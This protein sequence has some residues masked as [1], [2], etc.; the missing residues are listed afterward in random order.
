[1]SIRVMLAGVIAMLL[2]LTSCSI[3]DSSQ[4]LQP[5]IPEGESYIAEDSTF[6]STVDIAERTQSFSDSNGDLWPVAWSDDDH[7][8]TANGD[9]RGFDWG[10][11][12]ADIVVNRVDGQPA[13]DSMSGE[14]LASGVEVGQVWSDPDK[15]NK[16]PTGMISVDG[17][18]YMAVQDLNKEKSAATF[19]DV[20]AATIIKSTDKGLTW[21]WDK[22]KPMFSNYQFTTIMFLDYGK[23]GENNTFDDY[24]Y[25]YGLDYNWR[26][27][28]SD[29]VPDPTK[30]YLARMPKTAL[31]DVT[32]WEYYTGDLYGYARW[33]EPSKIEEKKPVL[34]DDRRVYTDLLQDGL[35]NMSVIS[36]SSIVYNKPLERYIYS[37]WTEFTF[38]FYEAPTP[39]GPWKKFLSKD[40]GVYPWTHEKHGGYATVIPSKFISENGK[41]MW[42]NGNTFVGGIEIYSFSLRK[43]KVTPYEK[44]KAK[45]KKNDGVNLALSKNGKDATTLT[46]SS[47]Y[48]NSHFMNDG[49]KEQSE[50][51]WNGEIKKE[52]YWGYTWSQAYRMNQLVYTTGQMFGTDGG[53]FEDMKVQVRQDFV[54]KDVDDLVISHDYSFDGGAGANTSYTLDF[55]NIWGDGVRLIGMP[56]G[57]GKFTSIAELEVYYTQ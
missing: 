35:S 4:K 34:R 52:D 43:L 21:T 45:N 48:G 20:P 12:W 53:W 13:D 37:S 16:K 42:V 51:S 3:E 2:L 50:D 40:F 7:L 32:K 24:I 10:H 44:T 29:T 1:M 36:Q 56:G 26:D 6:F 47:H 11:P 8:Y 18:L 49:I 25:A 31:Q 39:W 23:D 14:R 28:F 27:S 30:M 5:D 54:W 46:R 55:S 22:D 33:S 15:Y 57:T 41:E 19:N 38:E 17:V 9:G